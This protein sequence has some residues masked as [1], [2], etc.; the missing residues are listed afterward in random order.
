[1]QDANVFGM[2]EACEWTTLDKT[3]RD[4]REN[5]GKSAQKSTNVGSWKTVKNL[6]L[7]N[8]ALPLTIILTIV[9]GVIISVYVPSSRSVFNPEEHANFVG[10]SAYL[11]VGMIIMMIP[12]ICKVPWETIHK[13]MVLPYIKKQLLISFILNWICGP[14]LMTALAWMT[15]FKFKE[16]REGII[17]I[18]IARCIAMVL[19]WNQIAEGD[20]DLCVILVI[21]NSFFKLFFTFP[22]KYFIVTLYHKSIRSFSIPKCTRKLQSQWEYFLAFLWEWEYCFVYF[23]FMLRERINTSGTS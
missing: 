23:L 3:A 11:A 4:S 1:M 22:C 20:N 19:I 12:P 5:L 18:G 2:K 14:L 10:V 6:S 9:I 21:V 8:L 7:S 13:Y 17:M 16:Y 15:L